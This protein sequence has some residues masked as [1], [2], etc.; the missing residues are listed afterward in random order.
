MTDSTSLSGRSVS[1]VLATYNEREHIA[2]LI[3][4]LKAHIDQ[5]LEIIIVD[6]DSTDATAD[7]VQQLGYSEVKLIRRKQRGLASAFHRGILESTGT[8]VCWMDADATMPAEVLRKM[9]DRLEDCDIAIGSRYVE[10][11]SDNR[12][13]LRVMASRTINTLARVVL[14]GDVKDYDSG[15]VALRREVFDSVTIIPVGYGEYFIEMVYDAYRSGLRISEV[16]YAFTDRAAGVS[17]SMP[18][19]W[20]FLKTGCKYV[21]RIFAVRVR[22][23]IA[24]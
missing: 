24:G 21:Y 3:D 16:G 12:A 1:V 13:A 2:R 5:P 19:L 11:G 6:D 9:I 17:K 15:F 8:I 7:I 10:G 18:S 20:A 4:D 23:M 14:G 22:S